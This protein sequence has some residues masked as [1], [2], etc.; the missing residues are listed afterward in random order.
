MKMDSIL[1]MR[2]FLI[3]IDYFVFSLL[4]SSE[5]V[6]IP[7]DLEFTTTFEKKIC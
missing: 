2:F 6:A 4:I 1:L 7:N 5:N 3:N